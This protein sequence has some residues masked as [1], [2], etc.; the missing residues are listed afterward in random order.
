MSGSSSHKQTASTAE[1]LPRMDQL[2]LHTG[3]SKMRTPY[4]SRVN[5]SNSILQTSFIM[6]MKKTSIF[7]PIS[8]LSEGAAFI[9]EQIGRCLSVSAKS[10]SRL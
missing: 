9:Y 2:T 1:T 5:S 4:F 3:V 7:Y 10:S 8:Y 6:S